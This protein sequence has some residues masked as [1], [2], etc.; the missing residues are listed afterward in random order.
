MMHWADEQMLIKVWYFFIFTAGWTV[1]FILINSLN[2]TQSWLLTD[3]W[4]Y[5]ASVRTPL[6]LRSTNSRLDTSITWTSSLWTPR[7]ALLNV[8]AAIIHEWTEITS[9][10][11]VMTKT[12]SDVTIISTDPSHSVRQMDRQ[13]NRRAD[14][15]HHTH[16]VGRWHPHSRDSTPLPCCKLIFAR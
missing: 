6:S 13:T 10:Q 11:S 15:G 12:Y 7:T 14:Q 16:S 3:R 2:I 5:W 4:R 9:C 1:R 8:F